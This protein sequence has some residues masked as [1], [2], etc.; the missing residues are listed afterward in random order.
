MADSDRAR[1]DMASHPERHARF[2]MKTLADLRRALSGLGL[3]LP[4]E[5]DPAV[6][7]DA[8]AIGSLQAANRFIVHPM[9][10]FDSGPD[11]SPQELTFRRYRRYAEGGAGLIWFEATAVL[12]EARSNP[13]QLFIHK[14]NAGEFARLVAQTRRTAR[15]TFGREPILVLQLTHS[16]RYSKPA[17]IPAPLIAHHSHVLDPVMNLPEGYPLV[18]DAYLDKLQGTFV[19]AAGLAAEAGFDGVDI[20]SCHRYLVS[21][22]FSSFT[23]WGRYGGSF[24]NRTRLLRETLAR[25]K[26][27]VPGLFITTR[28][29]VYD[30]ISYPY[31]W[32]VSEQHVYTPDLREPIRLARILAEMGVP[33]L[34]VSIGNPYFNPHFGRPYDFPTSGV[35]APSEHPLVGVERFI[36]ITRQMQEAVPGLPIVA[37]GYGWLRH[38]MPFVAAGVV[39]AGGATLIGQG[40]GSFAYPESVRDIL[41]KGVMD[42]RKCCVTC[43]GCT[44]IMRDGAR[45]GCVVRDSAIYGPEYRRGRRFSM[46]RL[47][48]EAARCR[49]C[50]EATC[51][52]ACPAHVNIPAF[53]KAFADGDIGRAYAILR[54]RNVL[55]EMCAYVCPVQEQCQ[56]GCLEQIFAERPIP[57]ADIQLVT[58]RT[59]RLQGITGLPLPERASGRSVGIV[60]GGPAGLACAIGLLERGHAVTVYEAGERLGGTPDRLIPDTRYGDASAEVDAILAPARAAGRL[61][62]VFG[63]RLGESLALAALTERHDA[64]FL[65]PGLSASAS[66]GQADGVW[67]ALAFL[68]EAKRGRLALMG[69]RVAVLGGG[70]T[71]VDAALAAKRLG[72]SDVYVVYRRSFAEMPAWERERNELLAAGCH[73]MILTQPLGYVTAGENKLT[74]LKIVRTELGEPD[75]SGRRRPVAVP[76]TESVLPVDLAVEA[77]GQ[78]MPGSLRAAL[79]GLRLSSAG[80]VEVEPGSA[81]TSVDGVFAGGDVVNGGTTAVQGVTEGMRAAEEM[82]AFLRRTS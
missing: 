56:G 58:A 19:E 47:R 49:D 54:Q 28:M 77:I 68:A 1:A 34:N 26:A 50:E 71:A 5:E 21:E 12:H 16:G 78:T 13:G 18:S 36:G 22:C 37:S 39:K 62:A 30:A 17:G 32:G 79:A 29:N 14:G 61:A 10:G 53:V 35:R 27:E 31:G 9:E 72:A 70:N 75:E 81:R 38:L 73:L 45:T 33:V 80:L 2:H 3:T 60:G 67:D 59:A 52:Q 63:S 15:E 24:E 74:G 44:Q 20:K 66:I 42:P 51:S 64:V 11:G 6:L 55:P 69:R 48:E 46:D 76:G 40:R 4:I 43:S 8:V 25:I 41:E 57:I 7:G 23:R 65:A 82:D